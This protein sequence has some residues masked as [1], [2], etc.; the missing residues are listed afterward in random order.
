MTDWERNHLLVTEVIFKVFFK[1][2]RKSRGVTQAEEGMRENSANTE[3][4]VASF[5]WRALWPEMG[6][7]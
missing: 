1:A 2:L 7:R 5:E 4:N 6:Q 3:I